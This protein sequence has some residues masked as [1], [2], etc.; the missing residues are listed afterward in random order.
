MPGC[1]VTREVRTDR[2][3]YSLKGKL[4]GA[5]AWEL[6]RCI[7]EELLPHALL[8]FSQVE[9]FADYGVAVLAQALGAPC[10]PRLTGLRQHTER[11]FEYFGVELGLPG[12]PLREVG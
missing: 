10:K 11:L 12:D 5:T 7:E 6:R 8:D 1:Q 9:E 4:D 2:A 3:I